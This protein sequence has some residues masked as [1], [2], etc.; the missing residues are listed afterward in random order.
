MQTFADQ[1][2][3]RRIK[4]EEMKRRIIQ[5]IALATAADLTAGAKFATGRSK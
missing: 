2:F 3:A 5:G 1:W 4:K